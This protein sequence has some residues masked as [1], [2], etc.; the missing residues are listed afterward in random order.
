MKQQADVI[1]EELEEKL[2]ND[3]LLGDDSPKK[4]QIFCLGLNLAIRSGQ[5]HR[6]LTPEMFLIFERECAKPFLLYS[7]SGSKNNQGGLN[8]HHKV[9]NKS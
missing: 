3:K 5:E 4:L 8:H 9:L 6:R 7:E 2:W 1:S